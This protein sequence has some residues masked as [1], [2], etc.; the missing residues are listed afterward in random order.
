MQYPV[1]FKDSN[2]ADL[3]H[4]WSYGWALDPSKIL[5]DN[6]SSTDITKIKFEYTTWYGV[7]ID[8]YVQ[9]TKC[10]EVYQA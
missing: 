9:V 7:L 6:T 8:I 3:V 5:F 1:T 4:E 10:S 2:V